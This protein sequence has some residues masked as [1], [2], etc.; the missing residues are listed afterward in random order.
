MVN[1][2]S[3]TAEGRNTG[4]QVTLPEQRA[5]VRPAVCT[6]VYQLNLT[7]WYT[8]IPLQINHLRICVPLVPCVPVFFS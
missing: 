2:S 1:G 3:S 7:K 6:G 5:H 4:Q 8:L